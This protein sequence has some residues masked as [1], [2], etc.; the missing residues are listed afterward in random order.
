VIISLVP[1]TKANAEAF[2]MTTLS[3]GV[4]F[5]ITTNPE[6]VYPVSWTEK[7]AQL[8]FVVHIPDSYV[9]G[10]SYTFDGGDLFGNFTPQPPPTKD[11][12]ANGYAALLV[13]D[14]PENGGNG[15]GLISTADQAVQR[16]IAPGG[17]ALWVDD[18]HDGTAQPTEIYTFADKGVEAIAAGRYRRSDWFD[19]SGNRF[20]Y[21]APVR[22]S[23]GKMAKSFDVFLVLGRSS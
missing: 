11:R 21:T 1:N 19:D 23:N 13:W 16:G 14:S 22:L 9:P 18:N 8:A 6:W 12:E 4:Q 2:P 3:E 20:R 5:A 10:Q 7:H 17:I 15:D